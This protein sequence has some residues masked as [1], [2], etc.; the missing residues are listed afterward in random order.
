MGCH[1][2]ELTNLIFLTNESF[3]TIWCGHGIQLGSSIY[4]NEV[5]VGFHSHVQEYTVKETVVN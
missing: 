5:D 4:I 2:I 1:D 3:G